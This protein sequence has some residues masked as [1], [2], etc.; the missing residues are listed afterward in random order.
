MKIV[1]TERL[2]ITS[3]D[4]VPERA[5]DAAQRVT[6]AL[7]HD[8][9]TQVGGAEEV[10]RVLAAMYPSAPV[11]TS[12]AEAR[13]VEALGLVGR[14]GESPLGRVPGLRGRHRLATPLY[15]AAFAALGGGVASAEVVIADTSAWAH[16]IPVSAGQLLVA[17]CHS[18]ARFLYGD[19]DYLAA[20]DVRGGKRAVLTLATAPYRWWDRRAARRVDLFLANSRNV[21]E[22]IE[23]IYD[24][25]ARVVHPPIDVAALRP[26]D[27]IEVGEDYLVVSRLV[28]HKRVDLAIAACAATGARL[29]VIGEGRDESRLKAMAGTNVTFRGRLPLDQV[30]FAL[31]RSRA[32]LLPGAEDFGMTAVEAQAAGRPVIA[33]GRGGALESVVDG[34]TGILFPD[35]TVGSLVDAMRRLD[36]LGFDSAAALRNALRFDTAVFEA[37]IRE[38]VDDVRSMN[39]AM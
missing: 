30:R 16:L 23:R 39:R 9:L 13:V 4:A 19:D 6:V 36:A 28:P 38:A 10:L 8:Y 34:E 20:A 21:A 31:Q 27:G 12:L 15:P 14:V 33:Y 11:L 1:S 7:V 2:D 29:T 37:A 17:Y 26:S 3:H 18:P 22:R 25:E 24:R 32:L 35:P 5:T